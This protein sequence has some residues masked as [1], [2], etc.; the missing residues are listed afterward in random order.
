MGG[1][2]PHPLL[3]RQATMNDGGTMEPEL[4]LLRSLNLRTAV[5][6]DFDPVSY[7]EFRPW[8]L[9]AKAVN[10]SYMLSVQLAAMA[11]NVEA[12]FV[13]GSA[14]VYAPGL[15][16]F[17][18]IPGLDALGFISVNDLMAAANTELGVD[19]AAF[20]D[21]P[22]RA[23]Q[24]AL[25]D[26][27][28][29]A[30]N[31]ETFLQPGPC[32]IADA[33]LSYAADPG[34]P[35]LF[36]AGQSFDLDGTVVAHEWDWDKDGVL[37][38]SS[39][40]PLAVHY[41]PDPFVGEVGL[42]VTDD[43]GYIGQDAVCVSVGPGDLDSDL[44]GNCDELALE[45]DPLSQDTDSD[46]CA[47]GLELEGAPLSAPGATGLYDPLDPYDFDDVPAPANN[48]PIPNGARNKAVNVQDVVG[49]LKYVGTFDNGPSNGRVD[50]DSDKNGDGVKD[51]LGYDR[52]PSPAPNPPYEAGPPSGAINLSDVVTVLRQV[53]LS[54]AGLP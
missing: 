3:P 16:P 26:A 28:D 17:A 18:P 25:K 4:A 51:G 43:T 53:G 41:F 52:S 36:D 50:Y 19:G 45:T 35:V 6:G 27:L 44:L 38:E 33:G 14:L 49:V 24:A 47:D 46:G 10:M 40:S 2:P 13:D 20:A 15:L 30:N 29:N 7:D 54:C 48:D 11:L 37:D 8:L 12:G 21:S 1:L 22:H 32:P 39:G 9:D 34:I 42:H 5:G 31:D 23:Y